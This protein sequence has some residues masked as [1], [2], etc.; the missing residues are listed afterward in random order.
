MNCGQFQDEIYDYLDDT[1]SPSEKAAAEEH[2]LQCGACQQAMQ[3]EL[4]LARTLSTRLTQAVESVNLDANA[5][6]GITGAA[7]QASSDEEPK[8]HRS[9]LLLIFGKRESGRGGIE[10]SF[11]RSPWQRRLALPLAAAALILLGG[12]WAGR[13]LIS[14]RSAGHDPAGS[15]AVN[16]QVVPIH[17]SCSMPTYTFQREGNLVLDALTYDT[18]SMDGV[19]LADK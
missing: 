14:E 6:R 18:L 17:L 10:S 5:R 7:L 15:L 12:L 1:L 2:L 16:N 4:L 11:T 3:R 9:L 13:Q 8:P 19:L